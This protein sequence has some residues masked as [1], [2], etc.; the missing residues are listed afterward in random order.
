MGAVK[1][2]LM[3]KSA[4]EDTSRTIKAI[5]HVSRISCVVPALRTAAGVIFSRY[6]VP[7][8]SESGE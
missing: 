6:S 7:H 2:A 4:A 1:R 8:S 3:I 5:S